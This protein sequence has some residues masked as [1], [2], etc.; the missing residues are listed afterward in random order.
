MDANEIDIQLDSSE[1]IYV[2]IVNAIRRKINEKEWQAGD[3]LPSEEALVRDLDVSRGT[4]RKAV[5]E[6]V[7]EGVLERIQGKGTFVTKDKISYP[8]A[9]ELTSY[10]EA[11]KEKDL[12]FTTEV[13]V[14]ERQL[15]TPELQQRLNIGP[16]SPV[17]YM[18]RMRSVEGTPAILLYNWVSLERVPGA[19]QFDYSKK[20]VFEV[21]EQELG[22]KIK[23]GVRDFSAK[24]LDKDQAKILQ[25]K[26]GDAILVLKQVT[27]NHDDAPIECSNVLLRTDQYQVTSVLYR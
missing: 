17:L 3:R 27:F 5:T 20:S 16:R 19:D 23:C 14:S 18:V 12:S 21:I 2:Q 13:L 6:L 22:H 24:N 25:Q 8:F 9:Q 15:P 10:A 26:K 11:M 7:N 4:V 1:P